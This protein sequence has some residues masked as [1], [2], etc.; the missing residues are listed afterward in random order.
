MA[1]KIIGIYMITCTANGKRY[2]GQSIDI[3]R[4]FGQHRRN[5]PHQMREDFERYGVDAFS[6]EI[7]EECAPELLDEKE[8]TY[9]N[10]FQPEYNI[11]TEGHGISDEAR[12]KLRKLQ[13]GRK[14]RIA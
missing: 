6:F 13:T 7:M 11:R 4:R 10:E 9:M 5:P 1:K 14:L 3:K 2:I 12:E 8:T